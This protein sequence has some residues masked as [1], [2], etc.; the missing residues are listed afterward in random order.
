LVTFDKIRNSLEK[1]SLVNAVLSRAEDAGYADNIVFL[2][3]D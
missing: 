2:N 1:P 3:F